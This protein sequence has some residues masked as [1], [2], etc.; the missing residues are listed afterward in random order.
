MQ[1]LST[2]R[3]GT[4]KEDNAKTVAKFSGHTPVP[5][6]VWIGHCNNTILRTLQHLTKSTNVI[7][8]TFISI[9]L[10]LVKV[11]FSSLLKKHKSELRSLEGENLRQQYIQL[12]LKMLYNSNPIQYTQMSIINIWCR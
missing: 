8:S 10:S 9:L 4:W 7:H 3:Y 1:D 2:K 11:Q 6:P 5:T 12:L